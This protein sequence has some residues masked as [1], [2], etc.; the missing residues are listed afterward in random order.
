ME[1]KEEREREDGS[2]IKGEETRTKRDCP[3]LENNKNYRRLPL[4]L[5]SESYRLFLES[6]KKHTKR[7]L[8]NVLEFLNMSRNFETFEFLVG[9][10]GVREI[11]MQSQIRTQGIFSAEN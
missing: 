6:S 8:E 3:Y 5:C 1:E 4:T 10:T 9:N 7:F 11:N 2:R